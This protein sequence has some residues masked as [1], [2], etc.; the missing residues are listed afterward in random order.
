ML[1][2]DLIRKKNEGLHQILVLP[3]KTEENV[4]QIPKKIGS[5]THYLL[6]KVC[7][8]LRD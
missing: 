5:V 8:V 3:K 6:C 4:N 1:T 7:H 2:L